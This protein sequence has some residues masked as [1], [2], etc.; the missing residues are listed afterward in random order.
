MPLID[1]VVESLSWAAI[2][3]PKA[4]S[5]QYRNQIREFLSIPLILLFRATDNDFSGLN[6]QDNTPSESWLKGLQ[7]AAGVV[8]A[9]EVVESTTQMLVQNV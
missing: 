1:L 8:N 5:A 3:L 9:G 6:L 2:Q 7:A 4:M